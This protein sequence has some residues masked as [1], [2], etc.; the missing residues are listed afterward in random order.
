MI[1]HGFNKPKYQ[2]YHFKQIIEHHNDEIN[3]NTTFTELGKK[4]KKGFQDDLGIVMAHI[5]SAK[6][7]E[8]HME[9]VGTYLR[10]LTL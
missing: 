1:L 5:I 7:I 6:G 2:N 9:L 8:R 10:E 4:L 3:S